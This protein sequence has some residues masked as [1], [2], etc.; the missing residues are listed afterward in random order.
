MSCIP[1]FPKLSADDYERALRVPTSATKP[2]RVVLD[3]D[4]D[5]EVDDWYA[6]SHWR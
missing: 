4:L 6:L 3:T 5:N 2:L 1:D